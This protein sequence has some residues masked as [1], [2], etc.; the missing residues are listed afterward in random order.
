MTAERVE[1]NAQLDEDYWSYEDE[2]SDDISVQDALKWM[3]HVIGEELDGDH[4]YK[5]VLENLLKELGDMI[6]RED[7]IQ[8]PVSAAVRTV[9]DMYEDDIKEYKEDHWW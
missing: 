3:R 1:H 9:A 4:F 7:K 5:S 6:D 8:R 2:P